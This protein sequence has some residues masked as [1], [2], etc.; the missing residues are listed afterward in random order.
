MITVDLREELFMDFARVRL[1]LVAARLLQEKDTPARR[2]AVV[3]C[4]A[5]LDAL[6]DTYRDHRAAAAAAAHPA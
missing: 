5:K 6:L 4:L 1:E 3:T 2:E